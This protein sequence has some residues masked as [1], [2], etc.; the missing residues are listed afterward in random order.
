MGAYVWAVDTKSPSGINRQSKNKRETL[1]IY[2]DLLL[3]T[4]GEA[5]N[6]AKPS[7]IWIYHAK[8]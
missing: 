3:P 7:N 8:F 5:Y 4:L 1:G 2:V 6:R